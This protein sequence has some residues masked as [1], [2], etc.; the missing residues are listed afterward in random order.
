[1]CAP[2]RQTPDR[3]TTEADLNRYLPSRRESLTIGAVAVAY[4]LANKLALFFPDAEAI[5][6]AVWP[7]GGIALAALLR[8]PRR[9]W[10]AMLA[11]VFAAGNAANLL[12]GRP[13]ANSVGFM[14]ANV[15]ESALCAWCIE[16]ICGP[17]PRFS[18]VREIVALLVAAS[19]VNA[20]SALAGAATAAFAGIAPYWN[21]WRTW[22]ISDGLGILLVT[23]CV[24]AWWDRAPVPSPWRQRLEAAAFL[25]LWAGLSWLAFHPDKPE[26]LAPQPYMLLALL[27]WPALRLGRRPVTLA[28]LVL[29]VIAVTGS[30][31][32]L[33]IEPHVHG[34][35][36]E[37]LL[38]I[39]LFLGV[40]AIAAF[41][42]TAA[43]WER[44]E[45]EGAL[46]LATDRLRLALSVA[47]MGVW[48]LLPGTGQLAVTSEFRRVHGLDEG[49]DCA[50]AGALTRDVDPEDAQEVAR[51][52]TEHLTGGKNRFTDTF[53][54][55]TNPGPPRWLSRTCLV[56]RRDPAGRPLRVIGIDSDITDRKQAEL[57]RREVESIIRHDIKAPLHG[58]GNVADLARQG[59]TPEVLNRLY[60]QIE[61][62]IRQVIHLVDATDALS[63]ME[64]GCYVPKDE[65]VAV[66][67]LLAAIGQT[68]ASL[69]RQRRIT[70]RFTPDQGQGGPPAP[71]LYGEEFLLEN[72][73]TNLIKNAIEASP[74]DSAVS[75]TWAAEGPEWRI[76]IHNRGEIPEAVRDHFFEKYSSCGKAHGTGLGTYSAR[77]IALAHGG[78]I[79]VRTGPSEGTTVTV[80]LPRHFASPDTRAV[81]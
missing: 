47:D 7:A 43:T 48:D 32:P 4:F 8:L 20:T 44:R 76:A 39:Q 2:R 80:I 40:T 70:C 79:D 28:L 6:A 56:V 60:P 42:L 41:F 21:F 31:P 77:L 71:V 25:V 10:P 55:C 1:M 61:R 49:T 30:A 66:P 74:P 46:R 18:R 17:A 73:F 67:A 64:Q 78:R 26:T 68:L 51:R 58:L 11:V 59:N 62:G 53:R 45:A 65:P 37:H 12:S 81:R 38:A 27:A 72:M 52:F 33:D 75:V 22:M 15:L 3:H 16:G 57:F 24:L 13:L 63:R 35:P 5:L 34:E 9:L 50:D 36:V 54:L 19:V 23:P 69:A 29:A 14:A